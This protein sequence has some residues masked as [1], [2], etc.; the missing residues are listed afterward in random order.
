V[1]LG[2]ISRT[3]KGIGRGLVLQTVAMF[4]FITIYNAL[5]LVVQS[6]SYINNREFPGNHNYPPGPLA[7]WFPGF[8]S[9][10]LIVTAAILPLNQF[11]ADGL[12]VSVVSN[13]VTQI[14][15]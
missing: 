4:T 14:F 3:K 8:E 2:P 13:F 6:F 7:F 10:S 11:L 15:R 9:T 5:Q 12:L 1:L